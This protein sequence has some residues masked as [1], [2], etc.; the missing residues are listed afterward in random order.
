[1]HCMAGSRQP[2]SQRRGDVAGAGGAA[3]HLHRR[4][5]RHQVARCVL[6]SAHGESRRHT[7]QKRGMPEALTGL[8]DVDDL[9]LVEELHGALAYDEQMLCRLG[10]LDE[11]VL[12]GRVAACLRGGRDRREL[13]RGEC[14]EGRE[15][16]EKCG[17]LGRVHA[18]HSYRHLPVPILLLYRSDQSV[19]FAASA[20]RAF[21]PRRVH[22]FRLR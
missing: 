11:Y 13:V 22:G 16:P 2:L 10:V 7:R 21:G 15:A 3:E 12:A 14:I 6:V 8:E 17:D 20:V 9:L 1:M 19:T 4:L 5:A 18:Y